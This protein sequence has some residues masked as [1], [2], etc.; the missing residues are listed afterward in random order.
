MTTKGCWIFVAAMTVLGPAGCAS[1]PTVAAPVQTPRPQT[2]VAAAL[3]ADAS[4]W[5]PAEASELRVNG[6]SRGRRTTSIKSSSLRPSPQAHIATS[7][8]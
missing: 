2:T 3:P 7:L 8:R 1:Q 4:L 6:G 5:M